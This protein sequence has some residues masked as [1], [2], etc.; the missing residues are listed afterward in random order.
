MPKKIKITAGNITLDAELNDT[1]TARAIWSA[2]P[3][4]ASG[5]RWG[6]EIYFGIGVNEESD[7]GQEEMKVGDLAYWPP[8]DAFCIFF[9]RTPASRGSEPRAASAVNLVGRVLGDARQLAKVPSGAQVVIE[10]AEK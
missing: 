5:N 10:K 8:G 4:R 3:I 6:D 7:N 9:G 2:L 1:R